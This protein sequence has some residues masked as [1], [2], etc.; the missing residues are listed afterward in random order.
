MSLAFCSGSALD[1]LESPPS[2]H[3]ICS[4]MMQSEHLNKVTRGIGPCL[5]IKMS[6]LQG[7]SQLFLLTD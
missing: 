5:I 6:D 2:V 3:S 4:F 7:M 1:L